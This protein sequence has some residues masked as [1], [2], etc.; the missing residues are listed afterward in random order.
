MPVRTQPSASD[1]ARDPIIPLLREWLHTDGA[2]APTYPAPEVL[3]M[4]PAEPVPTYLQAIDNDV[5]P[6]VRRAGLEPALTRQRE[7][8]RAAADY[9]SPAAAAPGNERLRQTDDRSCPNV[10][11]QWQR[12]TGRGVET[13]LTYAQMVDCLGWNDVR[14]DAN[15]V[16]ALTEVFM[17]PQR[18]SEWYVKRGGQNWWNWKRCLPAMRC[19]VVL[20]GRMRRG[21]A[22][23]RFL[24]ADVRRFAPR[25]TTTDKSATA[26]PL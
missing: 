24:A 15:A 7:C 25:G 23:L 14:A 3:D 22:D 17:A 9:G 26:G 8:Y 21:G 12:L 19:A 5:W 16:Q 11:R 2:V 6:L 18:P 20:V 1:V 4:R 13:E 10:R